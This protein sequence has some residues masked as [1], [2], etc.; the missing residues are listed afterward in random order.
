L[1]YP[2]TWSPDSIRLRLHWAQTPQHRLFSGATAL[3]GLPFWG[4]SIWT[5]G[6]LT[7]Q[8]APATAHG[9]T[10]SF[11]CPPLLC[12]D[13]T[14][15]P[16]TA[17]GKPQA[18]SAPLSALRPRINPATGVPGPCSNN[19]CPGPAKFCWTDSKV[20]V[21][22]SSSLSENCVAPCP[23]FALAFPPF[24]FQQPPLH[25][26]QLPFPGLLRERLKFSPGERGL[27][28]RVSNTANG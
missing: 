25:L 7:P 11:R 27:T 9:P 12:V 4:V 5:P 14:G 10:D 18:F 22:L 21:M 24:L 19:S 8:G 26:S 13:S 3:S 6:S 16:F 23:S 15:A 17:S 1:R 2:G 28:R 20:F